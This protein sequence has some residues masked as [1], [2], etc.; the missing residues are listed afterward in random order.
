MRLK[1]RV[2]NRASPNKRT[3]RNAAIKLHV[4][5]IGSARE[6][7]LRAASTLMRA[8]TSTATVAAKS[9]RVTVVPPPSPPKT[10][11]SP[12]ASGSRTREMIRMVSAYF[13]FI[14]AI[15]GSAGLKQAQGEIALQAQLWSGG[16]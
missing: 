2:S 16:G 7:I 11:P 12:K 4:R 5:C 13:D 3:V 8:I 9:D 14:K 1:V 6:N 15:S 10:S